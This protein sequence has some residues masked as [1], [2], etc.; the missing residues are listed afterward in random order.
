MDDSSAPVFRALPAA[1]CGLV[2]L[3]VALVLPGCGDAKRSGDGGAALRSALARLPRL[4]RPDAGF[5]GSA[6]CQA[7]HEDEHRSWHASHHSKMTQ[8]ATPKS[9]L[10]PFDGI[11]LEGRGARYR[12]SRE[13]EAFFVEDLDA[14]GDAAGSTEARKRRIVMTTGSHHMQIFWMEAE[15]A[16]REPTIFHFCYL[17]DE[18]RWVPRHDAFLSDPESEQRDV[19][20]NDTCIHCHAT[21][22]KPGRAEDGHFDSLLAELGIA[23]EACHGPAAEHVRFH[24]LPENAEEPAHA[25]VNPLQLPLVEQAQVCGQCHSISGPSTPHLQSQWFIDGYPYRAGDDLWKTRLIVRHPAKVRRPAARVPEEPGTIT[26]AYLEQSFW[27]D[28]MIR[29]SG[30]EYNGLLESACYQRGDMTCL[31][32]HSMHEGSPDDQLAPGREGDAACLE[33]HGAIAEDVGAHTHHEV[34][35]SGSSCLNCHMPHTS[36]GLRK[37]MRSHEI[38]SPTVQESLAPVGRPNACNLCHLDQ[39]LAWTAGHLEAWYGQ[40]PP[41]IPALHQERAASLVW[42]LR[43]EAGQRALIAWHMGWPEARRTADEAWFAPSLSIAASSDPYAAVRFIAGRSLRNL[44]GFEAWTFDFLAPEAARRMSARDAYAR[45]REQARDP[46]LHVPR[47]GL[48]TD[49]TLDAAL[50]GR[51][52]RERDNRSMSLAE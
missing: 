11:T 29:V 3:C 10:A 14:A 18:K 20:W 21:G 41:E 25:I 52:Q 34:T 37:A 9:V 50:I 35:S 26:R 28:G 49:G 51:L 39:T 17:L 47:L 44:S 46:A 22:A 40:K 15:G 31:S 2:A 5:A 36:Y 1:L 8:V 48:G 23:C 19:I 4:G 43:G 42:L 24:E 7:C 13:G 30:R 32:C 27:N 6:S 12:L 38:S 33:C 45:W 16:E